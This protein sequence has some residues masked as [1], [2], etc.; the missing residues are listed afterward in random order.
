MKESEKNLV[1]ALNKI[2]DDKY[3]ATIKEHVKEVGEFRKHV[4]KFSKF[5][6]NSK[7]HKELEYLLN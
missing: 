1:S 2:G 4:N 6:K 5:N 3:T 7:L